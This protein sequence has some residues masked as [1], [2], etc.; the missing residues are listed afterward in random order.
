M[1]KK[2]IL[3]SQFI[4]ND[5]DTAEKIELVKGVKADDD[6]ADE[7]ISMLEMEQE[8]ESAF[9]IPAPELKETAKDNVVEFPV[10]EE[11]ARK[12]PVSTVA[13]MTALAAS[14]VLIIKVFFLPVQDNGIQQ[15]SADIKMHRFVLH[16]PAAE[17]V[18][19]TGSFSGWKNLDMKRIK[20][21]DYWQVLTPIAIGEHKY[22]FI[23]DGQTVTDPTV[24]AKQKDDFGGENSVLKVG[25]KI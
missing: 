18:A 5:L 2:E 23:V 12:F 6:F 13:S 19:V 9:D 4:D 15:I 1:N 3:I 24:A 10:R 25:D 14:L 17:T 20:G 16:M 21:T 22:A 11:K 7:A 8:M